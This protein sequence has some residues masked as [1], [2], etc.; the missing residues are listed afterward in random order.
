MISALLKTLNIQEFVN[1]DQSGRVVIFDLWKFEKDT[2]NNCNIFE[3]DADGIW[4]KKYFT[5]CDI[6]LVLDQGYIEMPAINSFSFDEMDE[7]E[8]KINQWTLSFRE[9]VSSQ[10]K[11]LCKQKIKRK[12][13]EL[14]H[15]IDEAVNSIL[16]SMNY[17]DYSF[18]VVQLHSFFNEHFNAG[19]KLLENL[20]DQVLVRSLVNL[21]RHTELKELF[22]KQL[23]NH[24][25]LLR[26]LECEKLNEIL[27]LLR[28]KKLT[29]IEFIAYVL[30][31][32]DNVV[33]FNENDY[34]FVRNLSYK[35][36]CVLSKD[37]KN[38]VLWVKMFSKISVGCC[39]FDRVDELYACFMRIGIRHCFKN[40][41]YI[42]KIFAYFQRKQYQKNSY[43]LDYALGYSLIENAIQWDRVPKDTNNNL[44]YDFEDSIIDIRRN[45]IING[46]LSL[47]QN[48]PIKFSVNNVTSIETKQ[49][50]EN[51]LILCGLS[52]TE[53]ECKSLSFTIYKDSKYSLLLGGSV[54]QNNLS[55]YMESLVGG[56]SCF[57]LRS[58]CEAYFN[59]IMSV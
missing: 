37:K 12:D 14:D 26:V 29:P 31:A 22:A 46:F 27:P 36:L 47:D 53:D 55:L 23:P 43:D 59:K 5:K 10:I 8:R 6:P 34:E 40:S 19:N 42:G 9:S 17:E 52:H 4:Q 44:I 45:E 30:K 35:S 28:S 41:E 39:S 1:I 51:C 38:F 11:M 49:L 20:D 2:K 24:L 54:G 18:K 16:K 25:A 21:E 57:S 32:I 58:S 50:W 13:K 3:K 33:N 7:L 56:D 15:A 48:S